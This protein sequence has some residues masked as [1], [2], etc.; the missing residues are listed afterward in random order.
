MRLRR[1]HFDIR[2]AF[3]L[4]TICVTTVYFVVGLSP[5]RAT[6][7]DVATTLEIPSIELNSDVT[8]L[9][10]TDDGLKTPD[11]IVGSYTRGNNNTLLIGHSTTVFEDL[12]KVKLGESII[13]NEKTYKVVEISLSRKEDIVMSEIIR[14]QKEDT[15]MLMTCAGTLLDG[16][17]A[18]H[19]LI[20][21]AVNLQ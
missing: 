15:L 14:G 6:D 1:R 17:D 4:I 5:V 19:R 9:S 11:T 7:Y 10:L 18:T 21:R 12:D 2:S 20:I 3:V 13:Y 16:G 8:K